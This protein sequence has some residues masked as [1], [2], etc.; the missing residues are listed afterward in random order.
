MKKL[1]Q[2]FWTFILYRTLKLIYVMD[3]DNYTSSKW[4]TSLSSGYYGSQ[5]YSNDRPESKSFFSKDD[6][7]EASLYSPK[8]PLYGSDSKL[9]GA[10]SSAVMKVTEPDYIV[11]SYYSKSNT[12][13]MLGLDSSRSLNSGPLGGAKRVMQSIVGSFDKKSLQQQLDF[14]D[15]YSLGGSNSL[16]GYSFQRNSQSDYD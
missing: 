11:R 6:L 4:Q 16:V 2:L 1:K 12:K 10:S 8:S 14:G 5:Y 3:L 7:T 9:R 15:A 13:S